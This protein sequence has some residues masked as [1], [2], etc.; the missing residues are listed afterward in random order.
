MLTINRKEFSIHPPSGPAGDSGYVSHSGG[1]GGPG[2]RVESGAA[3]DQS[4]MAMEP[5][6]TPFQAFTMSVDR[7]FLGK[8]PPMDEFDNEQAQTKKEM[9]LHRSMDNVATA[10]AAVTAKPQDT[11]MELVRL[12]RVR[13]RCRL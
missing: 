10:A 9:N 2:S 5:Q 12:L 13:N 1:S 4:P 6:M 8:P 7:G 3:L 11:G